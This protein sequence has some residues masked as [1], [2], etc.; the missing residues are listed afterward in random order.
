[1]EPT[2]DAYK[3]SWAARA[4]GRLDQLALEQAFG[5]ILRR[6]E[7]LRTTF[8]TQASRA[9]QVV[10]AAQP[11]PLRLVDVR[12][13]SPADQLTQIRRWAAEEAARP[14]DLATGPLLRLTLLA[15]DEQEHVLLLTAHHAVFDGWSIGVLVEELSALY[16]TFA[17]G[18]PSRLQELSVQYADYAVWQRDWLQDGVFETQLA[19]WKDRLRDAPPLLELPS[20]RPRPPVQRFQGASQSILLS[21][22]L[23][24]ELNAFSRTE[25][26]TLFMT[27]L[28]AFQVLLHRYTGQQDI[29]V[30]TPIAGRDRVEIEGLIGLF[31]NT[32]V[33]RADMQGDPSFSELLAQTRKVALDAYAHQA[34]PFEKLV[35]ELEVERDLSRTPLIQ[36]MFSLQNAPRQDVNLPELTF[37]PLEL[38]QT[39]AQ[40]DLT[41]DF[42]ETEQGLRG[43]LTYNTDLFESGSI[44]RMLG[45][46]ETLLAGI[47]TNPEQRLSELPL[48][49][50]S[51]RRQLLIA[52]NDTRTPYPHDSCVHELFELQAER[53]P[54]AV[55]VLFEDQQITYRD[56][57]VRVN[58]LARQLQDLGVGPDTLVGICM[59]RSLEMVVGLLGILKAGGAYLPLDPSYPKERLAFMLSDAQAPVLITQESLH[60]LLPECA[61]KVIHLDSDWIAA[62][63]E[64]GEKPISRAQAR[65]LAYVIYT[66]GSTGNPKGVMVSHRNVVNFFTA[67][68]DRIGGQSPGRWLAVTSISFDISVLEL[69]WT[70]TRGYQV[71]VQ[72]EQEQGPRT[73]KPISK[74]SSDKPMAFSLFYFASDE[75]DAAEDKYSLLLEGAKFADSNG[76]EA[77]WTPERHFHAFGGL[78][79]NP[80]VISAAIAATTERVRIRA[81]SVVLPL[82]DPIRVAEEWSVVDNLSNGR[83]DISFASGWHA[84]D[85]VFAP[86]NYADRKEV[87]RREI[88]TVRKLWRGESISRRCGSGKDVSLKI[89]PQP[90]QPVLPVW[91]TAGGNPETFRMAGELGANLLTHLLGQSV[92]EL[93]EK[94]AIYRQAWREHGHLP[95]EGRVTLMLHTY[96]GEDVDA[97]RE[98]VRRPLLDYLRSAVGLIRQLAAQLGQDIDSANFTDDD[99]EALLSHAFDRYFE[100]SGLLGTPSMCLDMVDRLQTIGVD[101]VA[102]LIDFG[103]DADAVMSGLGHLNTVRQL[104]AESARPIRDTDPLH[105]SIAKH[106]VSHLQCTPSMAV[107]LTM[108]E[109]SLAALSSLDKLMVGGEALPL[110]L[111]DQLSRQVA[112]GEVHNM[113]GPTE[114]TIWSSTYHVTDVGDSVPIGRPV[115]NTEI[116]ALDRRLHA[117]PIG[118]PGELSIG[119]D[120]VVR[121][122]LNRP[123]LTAEKFIPN[124]FGGQSGERIYRTGD[125][126]R[127]RADGNIEFLGRLDHQV[128]I[129][130]H[131]IE[132]GEIEAALG[133]HAGVQEA[134]VVAGTTAAGQQRLVAY[135]VSDSAAGRVLRPAVTP[136]EEQQL[137]ADQR[138]SRL[139]NGMI[140]AGHSNFQS[141][142][143]YEEVFEDAVYLRQGITLR[144]GDC[145]FDVGANVGG[146]TLFVHQQCTPGEMYAFEPMPPSFELLRANVELYDLNVK[147]FDFGVS[148]TAGTAEFTFYP[149]AAGWSGRYA[150]GD[151]QTVRSI[152][153]HWLGRDV[154]DEFR[155]TL[156]AGEVDDL[157]EHSFQSQAFTCQLRTLSDIMRENQVEQIDLLKIDVEKSELDVLQ[158]IAEE[159]W[160]KIKQLVIEIHSRELLEQISELLEG[161]SY[162]LAVHE[163]TIAEATDGE[164]VHVYTLSAIRR[165]VEHPSP[166]ERRLAT[167]E[168]PTA[169]RN[170][171][172][173]S[174]GELPEFL[175][176][177]LPD[178]MVP[179]AVVFLPAFPLTP[180][181]KVNRQALPTPEDSQPKLNAAFVPA[182]TPAEQE[183]AEVW[184]QVLRVERVGIHDNF[185]ELGGDSILT[186]QLIST[187][188]EAGYHFTLRQLFQ[189]QTIASLV[190]VADASPAFQAEQS[191]VTGSLPLTPIQRW[192]FDQDLRDPQHHNQSVLLEVRQLLD[193]AS[194][195]ATVQHL[196]IH[197]DAL[198]LRFNRGDAGWEQVVAPPDG[199]QT[200]SQVD[201]SRLAESEQTEVA[202]AV[203]AE[204]QASLNLAD[205]PLLRVVLFDMGP[206]RPSRLLIVIHHLVV[207]GVSWR[208]LLDDL[209]RGYEQVSLGEPIQL[210][211]KTTSYKQ[212]SQRLQDYA[213]TESLKQELPYWTADPADSAARLPRDASQGRN[214]VAS[215]RTIEVSLSADE[216]QSLLKEVPAAYRTEINDI[217]LTA[218]VKA[219]R[220]W[221][222]SRSLL[223]DLE[224]HGREEL[225]SD[226]ELSRTVGWFTTIFPVLL[227]APESSSPGDALKSIKEQLRAV[228]NRGIGYGVL[229][230]LRE[231][232][233][234]ADSLSSRPAPEVSFN[235]LGQFDQ[236]LRED[237]LFGWSQESNGPPHSPRQTRKYLLDA[238]GIISDGQLRLSL[239]YSQ[240]IHRSETI[241][242]LAQGFLD[243][244]RALIRHCQTAEAGG[245]TPSDF[246]LAN[247]DQPKLDLLLGS[248]R[249][250]ED[251][252]PLAPMQQGM[253]FHSLYDTDSQAYTLRCNYTL[254]GD[255][256]VAAFRR[257]WQQVVNRHPVLRTSFHLQGLDQPLQVVHRHV[258]LPWEQHDWR[259]L[260]PAEQQEQLKALLLA[261]QE[262]GFDLTQAPLTRLAV[263]QLSDD[264]FQSI[265]SF[266]HLL[267][268]RWS[269]SSILN[270]VLTC[271]AACCRG[272]D[273][274]FPTPRPYRDYIS[275]LADQDGAAAETFWRNRLQG[276]TAPTQLRAEWGSSNLNDTNA[277]SAEQAVQLSADVTERL[278]SLARQ[279]SLA[280][281]T[282]VQGTWALLLKRYTGQRDITF[283][284]SVSGRPAELNGIK[285]MIGLFTNTLP[286]RVE[287]AGEHRL[288]PW[289]KE[290]QVQQLEARSYEYS[291]LA[292]LRRWSDA[293]R[294]VPLF[295]SILVFGNTPDEPSDSQQQGTL[296]VLGVSFQT[297]ITHPLTVAVEP[298]PELLIRLEYDRERFDV[299]TIT[300]M[301]ADF[302]SILEQFPEHLESSLDDIVIAGSMRE[303]LEAGGARRHDDHLDQFNFESN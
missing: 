37:H 130:G 70:L 257:A 61:A 283:G 116:Y 297:Q 203:A 206:D 172:E 196:Q 286:V 261:D 174:A 9:F 293:P 77:V 136:E 218:L 242:R 66:S 162:A 132:I 58:Q 102:C 279:E 234:I 31:I 186:I 191:L 258:T 272:E 246:P 296:Q 294:G 112:S 124:P 144:D 96:V 45:N 290:L 64:R 109:G 167:S 42:E 117:A 122:Y 241:E 173:L 199:K 114:T 98:T 15:L 139:P 105:V 21:D 285:Q 55:A 227:Q 193:P 54:D 175:K 220:D 248:D 156:T 271:Y 287:V 74:R 188:R 17:S 50:E 222:G 300:T 208:V 23:T 80:A 120:G 118:L 101:E 214:T 160:R 211:A 224:G 27:L 210:P 184:A 232:S 140:L 265:L 251:I 266:H 256:D 18:H 43:S 177:T 90:V 183:L 69:L 111:A 180:N 16:Q 254:R 103:V 33:L 192:F 165:T 212:W 46:F 157:L 83:V 280:L 281:N 110:P 3:I 7:A 104:S 72:G 228:P 11:V 215:A 187:A 163:D 226:I 298:G 200:V 82:H 121:G 146:F 237:S 87:M 255:L 71:I 145:V 233:E 240:D 49:S 238:I 129:R 278:N 295:E 62:N 57:D 229:R 40:L 135:V 267:L 302:K 291:P 176:A 14:F 36:V 24:K 5:E 252:Y 138:Y 225:F 133:R 185:F 97:V 276:L 289:L 270:E 282:L 223:I 35:D 268:D 39:T 134:V 52:W 230:Y 20:D 137:L 100:T 92:E 148:N 26:A 30:G 235:Y 216:T 288:L 22:R 13:S 154:S 284:A 236:T 231:S 170:G 197:H 202:A 219:F 249:Q 99:M 6:H 164:G 217:L 2:G 32:L 250:V 239:R 127:Y 274:A 75:S 209:Q 155:E 273:A 198:R 63:N 115:A 78:Y 150:D 221:T 253:L 181:G 113:Y 88:E 259:H 10:G 245:C 168:K 19:H 269:L 60:A 86:D 106:D 131:R 4:V 125:L 56:L 85:F 244:L 152:L 59:E 143:L 128:K 41:F 205:G 264:T 65:K 190:A 81:G 79:P 38:E 142:I 29:L 204:A 195:E 169:G 48:L 1:M 201:L 189:H 263:V 149:Q 44:Q 182:S 126:S 247:L 123:D 141:N 8:A 262:K 166:L 76:F 84:D 179:Q 275:W 108:D 94:I 89:F 151:K 194:L 34:L 91:V 107:M 95:E 260:R 301:L 67:M 12:Q 159:D 292:D 147:L 277:I 161:H 73:A 178:Y 119:G 28:A 303:S 171:Q 25:G 68:D 51:E 243:G 207:D 158:G 93:A 53:S 153:R 213:V 47:I 299:D